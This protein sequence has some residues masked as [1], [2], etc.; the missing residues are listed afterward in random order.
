MLV[1]VANG[2]ILTH[3]W[4]SMRVPWRAL[5]AY[6]NVG[7]SCLHLHH[8]NIV[9]VYMLYRIMFPTGWNAASIDQVMNIMYLAG[10]AA[11]T[12][13]NALLL[14]SEREWGG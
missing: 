2:I 14:V 13:S 10:T 9:T 12:R 4:T 8:L 5:R 3:N 6:T 7:A 11:C 1:T